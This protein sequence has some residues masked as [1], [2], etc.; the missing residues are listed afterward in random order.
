MANVKVESIKYHTTEGK[1]YPVGSTY[2]VD[3]SAVEN[4]VAQGMALRVDRAE[5]A[6]KQAA[7]AEKAAKAR[8]SGTTAVAPMTTDSVGVTARRAR[9]VA[10]APR[11]KSVRAKK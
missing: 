2:S 1:E 5:V 11:A 10:K 9:S 3:E 6:K 8:A 7:E 4:L